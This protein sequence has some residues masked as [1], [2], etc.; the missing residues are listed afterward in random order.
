ML[1]G[2]KLKWIT[3]AIWIYILP[4]YKDIDS[5]YKL[6]KREKKKRE[7]ERGRQREQEDRDM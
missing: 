5:S 1:K 4:T 6:P 3:Q 7:R 2:I